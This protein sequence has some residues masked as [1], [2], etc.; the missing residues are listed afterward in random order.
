M[1]VVTRTVGGARANERRKGEVGEDAN[2]AKSRT[3]KGCV[4]QRTRVSE[5]ERGS[6]DKSVENCPREG[7]GDVE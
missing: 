6:V 2:S 1:E 5:L 7:R 3:S 4:S